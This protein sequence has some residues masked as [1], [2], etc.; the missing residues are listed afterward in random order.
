MQ[1]FILEED[2]KTGKIKLTN[3]IDNTDI[4]QSNKQ[5]RDIIGKGFTKKKTMRKIASIPLNTLISMGEK[6]LEIYLN[7][8]KLREF[9]K[10]HPEYRVS[11][12]S[13]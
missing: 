5:E 12:G 7:D 1:R 4:L 11:E 2:K 3:I 13:I 10:E 8:N 9:L 6:G